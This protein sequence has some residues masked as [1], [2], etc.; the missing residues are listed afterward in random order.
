MFKAFPITLSSGMAGIST[1]NGPALDTLTQAGLLKKQGMTYELTE[2]GRSAWN[3][4]KSGFCYSSGYEIKEIK[5]VAPVAPEKLGSAV[6]QGWTVAVD[7]NQQKVADWAKSSAIG[8]LAGRDAKA[9]SE[10]PQTY[11]V[12][13][14]RVRGE[15]GLQVI[16]PRFSVNKGFGVGMA[17]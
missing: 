8:A 12:I 4:E 17:W 11:H 13:L 14:G 5:D 3:A 6:E 16:D 2:L 15:Q 7:I 10:A 1:G 9:V